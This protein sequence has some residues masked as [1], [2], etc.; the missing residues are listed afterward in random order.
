MA[1]AATARARAEKNARAQAQI[2]VANAQEQAKAQVRREQQAAEQHQ[3]Q[4]HLVSGPQPEHPPQSKAVD[5]TGA[6]AVQQMSRHQ[7]VEQHPQGQ[8]SPVQLVADMKAMYEVQQKHEQQS[9]GHMHI[10]HVS[11]QQHHDAPMD[12][13]DITVSAA[14]SAAQFTHAHP[15]HV[16]QNGFDVDAATYQLAGTRLDGEEANLAALRRQQQQDGYENSTIMHSVSRDMDV[17]STGLTFA[18]SAV[19]VGLSN[20]S[21]QLQQQ[22]LVGT[23]TR[24]ERADHVDNFLNAQPLSSQPFSPP[25][26]SQMFDTFRTTNGKAPSTISPSFSFLMKGGF[27]SRESSMEFRR[28]NLNGGKREM[29]IEI[30]KRDFSMDLGNIA[31]KPSGDQSGGELPRD[32]SIDF[33][34]KTLSAANR[35]FSMEMQFPQQ[36]VNGQRGAA[37]ELG[38]FGDDTGEGEGLSFFQRGQSRE[39]LAR[40]LSILGSAQQTEQ[41]RQGGMARSKIGRSQDDLM[42]HMMGNQANMPIHRRGINGSIEDFR[43]VL[44]PF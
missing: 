19:D 42:I 21:V 44:H 22:Q 6:A 7:G 41:N 4:H 29:S 33:L 43:E 32:M 14:M 12:K 16:Q 8:L 35:D 1:D 13:K 28:N 37:V 10:S 24:K 9:R 3:Q 27:A 23:N 20:G 31:R 18:E 17:S 5:V 11:Q 34:G 36:Q 38:A 2:A 40:E 39:D 30:L 25:A 26:S 15:Q